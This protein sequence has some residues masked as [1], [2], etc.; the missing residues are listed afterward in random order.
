[1]SS[2]Q[3]ADLTTNDS[4][5]SIVDD[6]RNSCCHSEAGQ[7]E[8]RE[9]LGS[10]L[11]GLRRKETTTNEEGTIAPHGKSEAHHALLFGSAALPHGGSFIFSG[12]VDA[13]V[14]S[15]F[16]LLLSRRHWL[17]MVV[18][19]TSSTLSSSKSNEYHEH[20]IWNPMLE[21]LCHI[22]ISISMEALLCDEDMG[23]IALSCHFALDVLCD[24]E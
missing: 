18:S 8:A 14:L 2:L 6:R 20:N 15:S 9:K 7:R 5:R 17:A 23:R 10:R 4:D 1:M 3:D 24:K 11:V 19:N 21:L 16:F 13:N 12:S 22:H